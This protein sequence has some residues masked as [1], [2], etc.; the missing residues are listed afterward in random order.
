MRGNMRKTV[1]RFY[2]DIWNN[3]DK[4]AISAVLHEDF[5]FR[6]SL[7][8]EKKGHEGFSAYVDFVHKALDSYKCVIEETICEGEKLFARMTFSGFHRGEFFGY[9][10][11]NKKL[12]WA[13]AAIFTFNSGKIKELWVLGDVYGLVEQLEHHANTRAIE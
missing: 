5:I 1:D 10:P 13:G 6:G 7:G 9:K 3:Y 8:Q 2:E 4:S 12:T 11:T